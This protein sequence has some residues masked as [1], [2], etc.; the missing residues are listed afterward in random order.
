MLSYKKRNPTLGTVV[1]KYNSVV[2]SLFYIPPDNN[3]RK[4]RNKYII[5]GNNTRSK[6]LLYN[7][8]NFGKITTWTD[9]RCK[10]FQ[11]GIIIY[12]V[13]LFIHRHTG[14][15]LYYY[16]VV[17][18]DAIYYMI[19]TIYTCRYRLRQSHKIYTIYDYT[20]SKHSITII[21][22]RI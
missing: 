22:R 6:R 4:K 10:K 3:Y 9:N 18:E 11:V 19:K 2:Y 17:E 20:V 7:N 15:P 21:T 14:T 1:K 8:R 5:P 13:Y 16:Y 12:L